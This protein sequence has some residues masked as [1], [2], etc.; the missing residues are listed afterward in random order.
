MSE[1]KDICMQMREEKIDCLLFSSAANTNNWTNKW[2]EF[3]YIGTLVSEWGSYFCVWIGFKKK[4]EIV[5]LLLSERW[6]LQSSGC[7]R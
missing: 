3:V 6:C 5:F 4:G 2:I 1:A 7:I